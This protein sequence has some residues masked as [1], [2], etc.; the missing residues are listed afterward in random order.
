MYILGLDYSEKNW[1]KQI[2][3]SGKSV[4]ERLDEDGGDIAFGV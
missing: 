4:K 1:R 2:S 3:L